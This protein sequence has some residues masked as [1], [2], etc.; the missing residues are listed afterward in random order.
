MQKQVDKTE[1]A[2]LNGDQFNVICAACGAFH[3]YTQNQVS[4][5]CQLCGGTLIAVRRLVEKGTK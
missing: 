3:Y 5:N 2:A 4:G 1:R